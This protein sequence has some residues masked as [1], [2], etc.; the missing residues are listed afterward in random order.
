VFDRITL[1]GAG[2]TILWGYHPAAELTAW[3]IWK[4]SDGVWTL[5]GRVGRHDPFQCRQ[6]PLMF[7]APRDKGMWAWGI[8]GDVRIVK[9]KLAAILGPPEQ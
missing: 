4:R 8:E 1:H 2:A 7:T 5:A 3:R 6:S 9:G